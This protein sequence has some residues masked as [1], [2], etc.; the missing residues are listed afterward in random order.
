MKYAKIV[1]N[2][3][4]QIQPNK[5]TGFVEVDDTVVCGMVQNGDLF[6][7]PPI[8]ETQEQLIERYKTYYM[9]VIDSKLNEL[10]YDSLAT[11]QLWIG[12]ATFGAEATAILTWY[13]NIIAFNYAIINDIKAGG[14]IPTKEEYLLALPKYGA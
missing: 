13:K 2:I 5:E 4:V 11:V 9:K 8:V 12:D 10:D 7:N 6:E 14:A 3:A 1:N